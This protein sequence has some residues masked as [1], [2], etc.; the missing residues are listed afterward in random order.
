MAE[1]NIDIVA[2]DRK[3]WSGKGTFVFTRTTAGEIGILPNHIPLVAQLVDDAMV[4]VEREGEDD[5]RIAVDGGFLSVTE[6]G[7]S[8]LAESA[9]FASEIDEAAAERDAESDDPRIAARGR[10]RLR[11]LGRID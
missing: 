6:Q 7:V 5:L 11:A 3:I 1:L 4:R 9:E 10:A 8:V 2:V